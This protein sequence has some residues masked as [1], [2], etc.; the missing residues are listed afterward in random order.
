MW[1]PLGRE[2]VVLVSTLSAA[3]CMNRIASA[4]EGRARTHQANR[5]LVR[6]WAKDARFRIAR[7]ARTRIPLRTAIVG[8][9][10]SS[11]DGTAIELSIGPNPVFAFALSLLASVLIAAAV[12]A[13]MT[14]LT[15]AG[16]GA[17]WRGVPLAWMVVLGYSVQFFVVPADTHPFERAFL[18]EFLRRTLDT[19]PS[20]PR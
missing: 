13:T 14:A 16:A 19:E 5:T 6:G 17:G 11:G 3:D 10:R 15:G 18:L 1:T 8:R 2:H 4:T 7:N 9:I 20:L 12:V